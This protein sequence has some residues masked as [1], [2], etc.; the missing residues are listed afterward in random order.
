STSNPFDTL[1]TVD[2]DDELGANGGISKTIDNVANPNVASTS[3]G[4]NKDE[5]G[6]YRG[7]N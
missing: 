4:M 3:L 7:K 2:Y 1:K 5:D 6:S